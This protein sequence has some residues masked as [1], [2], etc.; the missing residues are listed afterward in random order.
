MRPIQVHPKI[1]QLYEALPSYERNA[2]LKKHSSKI[3]GN[4]SVKVQAYI[5]IELYI[6]LLRYGALEDGD[7]AYICRL[8]EDDTEARLFRNNIPKSVLWAALANMPIPTA[9]E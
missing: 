9:K 4:V 7:S 1:K 5:P 3:R 6:I 2:L 8:M